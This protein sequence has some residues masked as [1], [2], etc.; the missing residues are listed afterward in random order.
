MVLADESI[1]TSVRNSTVYI[2][3]AGHTTRALLRRRC[4]EL[5]YRVA[6]QSKGSD[7]NSDGRVGGDLPPTAPSSSASFTPPVA[8]EKATR[9][10]C[11]G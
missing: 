6:T 8:G 1:S 11:L 10:A 5:E 3:S 9:G 4:L 2:P 7:G